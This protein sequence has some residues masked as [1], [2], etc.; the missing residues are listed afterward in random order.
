MP[1]SGFPFTARISSPSR[2]VPSSAAW[3]DSKMVLTKMPMLPLGES[4]PPTMLKPSDLWPAPFWK[5]TVNRLMDR[6]LG[7]RGRVPNAPNTAAEP[8]RPPCEPCL[9][10]GRGRGHKDPWPDDVD[11]DVDEDE[12]APLDEVAGL[13]LLLLPQLLVEFVFRLGVI[14]SVR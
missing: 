2:R 9:G 6:D 8:R 13:P 5:M 10:V 4:W 3:P 12:D 7:L 14:C 11:E 1:C